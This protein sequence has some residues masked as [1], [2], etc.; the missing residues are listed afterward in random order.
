[1]KL[2]KIFFNNKKLSIFA[3]LHIHNSDVNLRIYK[4]ID[5]RLGV[6]YPY[7]NGIAISVC[8]NIGRAT[9]SLF[10]TTTK[11]FTNA[12][13][14]KNFSTREQQYLIANAQPSDR[15][16]HSR[17]LNLYFRKA[18]GSFLSYFNTKRWLQHHTW[19]RQEKGLLWA[20]FHILGGTQ[21]SY[22]RY[23]AWGRRAAY[24]SCL[25]LK[26]SLNFKWFP[27]LCI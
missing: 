27:A 11:I 22:R 18:Q 19:A 8:S 23:E 26:K 4:Y 12:T 13:H 6:V 2:L 20:F 16:V 14:S 10:L 15:A 25:N 7:S 21:Q 9:L 5:K 24:N 1:M 17:K 3:S